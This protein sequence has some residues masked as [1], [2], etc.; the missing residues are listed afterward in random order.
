MP[1]MTHPT[2]LD[3]YR[4]CLLGGAVGDSL[5][6]A[7]EFDTAADIRRRFGP[8]GIQ[9]PAEA[10]GRVGA[11]TDDTQMTLFT[12]EGLL[13]ADDRLRRGIGN[14]AANLWFAYQR[15]LRTQGFQ[16]AAPPD[17]AHLRHG[18]L[19]LVRDLH[20]RRAPGNTCV[21][22]LRKGR[23]P[24]SGDYVAANDSKGCGGVMRAAPCGLLASWPEEASF[25]AGIVSARLTH[26][27][28]SGYIA[29]GALAE[30]IRRICGGSSLWSALEE[31]VH[32][33]SRERGS[34]EVVTALTEA[35][36]RAAVDVH[37]DVAPLGLGW[38]AEEALAIA[39]YSVLVHPD[40]FAAAVRLAANHSGDSDSTA[41]IAG[42][43]A[44]ALLGVES[45]PRDWLEVL[46]IRDTI[47]RLAVAM[48]DRFAAGRDDIDWSLWDGR[49]RRR[50][51]ATPPHDSYWV[52]PGRLLAGPYPGAKEG[53]EAKSKLVDFLDLGV[54]CFIDLTEEGEGELE[55]YA[56]LLRGLAARRRVAV[57]H[58]RM[59]I[60]DNDICPAWRMRAIQDAIT[61]A[62]EAE[63]LVYVH[64]WGGVGRTGTV[65]SC[66]LIEEEGIS[67][68]EA[69]EKLKT[70]R[71]HTRR[72]HRYS[73]ETSRQREMVRNW[74]AED[75]SVPPTT[76]TDSAW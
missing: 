66:R 57:T 38:V 53:L 34:D 27:H 2:L 15:W 8:R 68:G 51:T 28:P 41:A 63:E 52:E 25:R 44:G 43:I 71:A 31:A 46:E 32:A 75:T 69:I 50:R 19:R 10:Y 58:L 36:R 42:N 35:R 62:L 5:G 23:G 26:G 21:G 29:A 18:E 3:R 72:A 64:C 1:A 33:A 24:Q 6:A 11:I 47:D 65:I 14:P 67:G 37:P 74:R 39:V 60:R 45:I 48:H 55:P 12:A 16:A 59:P 4:G 61:R 17:P 73:P 7:V 49:G 22:A 20:Q 9:A 40:D 76:R 54:T 56:E 70:L 13:Q 30:I